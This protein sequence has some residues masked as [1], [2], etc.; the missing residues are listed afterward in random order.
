[1][2]LLLDANLSY[3]IKKDL[4]IKYSQCEHVD[5]VLKVPS[6]DFEIWDFAL[7][8]DYIIV[9]ND[10][11]FITFSKQFGF[12]PKCIILKTGNQSNEYIKN[13]LIA[14]YDKISE[15]YFS[16]EYGILEVFG[17]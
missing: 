4:S 1:M 5:N 16:I 11:D 6:K 3:R 17:S 9:S 14:Q 10:E 15:F 12:P 2:K 13:L 7:S 8:N